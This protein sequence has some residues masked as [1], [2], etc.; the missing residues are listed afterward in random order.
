MSDKQPPDSDRDVWLIRSEMPK[1][2]GF[3][4]AQ[5]QEWRIGI[6]YYKPAR[7]I[8]WCEIEEARERV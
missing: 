8:D 2:R 4:Y 5:K 7:V 6:P 1:I 3:W